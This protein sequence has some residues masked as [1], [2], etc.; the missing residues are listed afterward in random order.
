MR[1]THTHTPFL[2]DSLVHILVLI[3]HI[4]E[5]VYYSKWI[6]IA[7]MGIISPWNTESLVGERFQKDFYPVNHSKN[8]FCKLFERDLGL[9]L[10]G[11]QMRC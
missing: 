8:S 7:T 5:H 11:F 4:A 6:E 10:K 9:N 3:L 2:S 1:D